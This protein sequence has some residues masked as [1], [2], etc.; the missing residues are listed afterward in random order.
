MAIAESCCKG[1]WRTIKKNGLE[2]H[3]HE[4]AMLTMKLTLQQNTSYSVCNF[5]RMTVLFPDIPLA[6]WVPSGAQ[7]TS[8]SWRTLTSTRRLTTGRGPRPTLRTWSRCKIPRKVKMLFLV[9]LSLSLAF[10]LFLSLSLY[11]F[12][13]FSLC[14]SLTFSSS[15]SLCLSSSLSWSLTFSSY[16]SLPWSL[17]FSV[18]RSF[19]R[20]LSLLNLLIEFDQ[21]VIHA[22]IIQ[23]QGITFIH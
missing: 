22:I 16:F 21:D 1:K 3:Y 2:P 5:N 17:P 12:L 9:V 18:F 13:S 14:L 10:S 8:A 23:I 19:Y 15:F 6:F 20:I 4:A 7:W 11:S